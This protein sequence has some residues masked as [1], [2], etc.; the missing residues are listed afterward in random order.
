MRSSAVVLL[1][2]LLL[3]NLSAAQYGLDRDIGRVSSALEHS[4]EER[5]VRAFSEKYDQ[6]WLEKYVQKDS[7]REFSLQYSKSLLEILPLS[8]LLYSGSESGHFY[9]KSRERRL[10]I[11]VFHEDGLITSLGITF[12]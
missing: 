11:T 8:D 3:G 9:L 7:R 10:V 5:L 1:L 2:L 12:Y 6:S 4:S